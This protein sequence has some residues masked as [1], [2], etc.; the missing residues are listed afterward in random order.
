VTLIIALVCKDAVVL[1]ADTQATEVQGGMNPATMVRHST[2]KI[3]LLGKS[4]AWAG[5]GTVS[6]LQDIETALDGWQGR[7]G[8]QPLKAIK[9]LR[10]ELVKLV[11]PTQKEAYSHW[12][13]VPAAA[14]LPPNTSAL[15]A[16]YSDNRPWIMEISENGMGE[17]KTGF[18]AIGGAYHL[19]SV[20]H[21][22]VQHYSGPDLSMVNGQLLTLRVLE[23]AV[24]AAGFGVAEPLHV[25]TIDASGARLLSEDDVRGLR[26]QVQAWKQSESEVLLSIA[27][28]PPAAL[29]PDQTT[30][31]ERPAEAPESA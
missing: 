10:G 1:A 23:T 28:V 8:N 20:A 29:V 5:S 12:V 31:G 16:G 19:A 3:H 21:A 6:V 18:A 25:A 13:P 17:V 14:N 27:G 4:M 2:S 15:F 24:Q 22:M 11:S 9:T 7:Q 30:S 26:D